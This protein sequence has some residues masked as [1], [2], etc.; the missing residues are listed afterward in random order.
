LPA[1]S[2]SVDVVGTVLDDNL[3]AW[4][5]RYGRG[6]DPAA[7]VE[8]ARSA[9]AGS[10]LRLA[11]WAVA[12]LA[13]DAYVLTLEATDRAG[14]SSSARRAV[15]LDGRPP[16]SRILAPANG[17]TLG[18]DMTI[19]GTARDANLESWRLESAPGPSSTALQWSPLADGTSAVVGDALAQ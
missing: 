8:V 10:S 19:T 6:S 5:L 2:G 1:E 4:V 18:H 15:T 12:S 14:H 16:E 13:D 7:F 17:T 3:D 9:T 11:S